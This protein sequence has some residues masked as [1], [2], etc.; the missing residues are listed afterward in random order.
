MGP[1]DGSSS[2]GGSDYLDTAEG[3]RRPTERELIDQANRLLVEN[4]DLRQQLFIAHEKAK[5]YK[6]Y[7]LNQRGIKA[8]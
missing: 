2:S 6:Q 8:S 1:F 4:T 3:I 7:W 5:L